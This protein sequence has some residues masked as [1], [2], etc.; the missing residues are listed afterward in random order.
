[1]NISV[2]GLGQR[3]FNYMRWIKYFEHDVGFAAVCDKN[4]ERT[5]YTAKTY[6][7]AEKFYNEDEFFK[8]CRSEAVIVATQDRDHF[9]HCIRCIDVGYKYILCEKPVSPDIDEC[10]RLNDYAKEKGVTVVVCH[11][12]RYS[13]YYKK[14]KEIIDSGEIGEVKSIQHSENIGYFHFAHSYVRGNWHREEDTSPMILAKCC[15]DFDILQWLIGKPAV[16]VTSFG[17]LDYFTRKNA[18]EGSALRCVDCKVADCKYNAVKLYITDPLYRCTFLRFTGSV[19]TGKYKYTKKDKYNALKT[20]D[21]GKCAF[22]CDNDVCDHQIVNISYEGGVT[23]SH[24]VSAFNDKFMRRTN[25]F[26]TKGEIVADDYSGQIRVS[27]FGG[28]HY[29]VNTKLIKGLGHIDG[30]I[31]LVKGFV[32]LVKGLPYDSKDVT[33]LSETITSH[34]TAIYAERSRREGG[35]VI[36]MTK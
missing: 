1:M 22:K 26:C 4:I 35:R 33:F 7:V 16:S 11:V 34:R 18:P 32:K 2:I 19:I 8:K 29:S 27:V 21:Y 12:L 14:I 28:R 20:T 24:T 13:K 3:G 30:D 31:N 23:A 36:K 6:G 5:D 17:G 10:V 25:V 9:K 15:H